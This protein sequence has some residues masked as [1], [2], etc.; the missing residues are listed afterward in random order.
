MITHLLI[1][2]SHSA[3]SQLYGTTA[4]MEK[5]HFNHCIMIL[6]S[7]GHNI[8]S[9]LK[10]RTYALV[11]SYI[12]EAIL[13]TDLANHFEIRRTFEESVGNDDIYWNEEPYCSLL[14]NHLMTCCDLAAAAKP[15]PTH[16]DVVNLVTKEFFAQGD[17]ERLEL[18]IEPQEMMDARR[19]HELPRL[20]IG[21][22]DNVC[23]PLYKVI[24]IYIN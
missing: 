21:W 11:I 23:M 3:L 19:S 16:R 4:T 6:N 22:I 8:F 7:Q 12:K 18:H 10:P 20:Q 5:H 17:R 1:K 14:R 9:H 13:A 15:W 24:Y 2:R